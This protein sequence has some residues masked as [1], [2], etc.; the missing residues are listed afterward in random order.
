[1]RDEPRLRR[2]RH[3]RQLRPP[4][5]RPEGGLR[6]SHTRTLVAPRFSSGCSAGRPPTASPSTRRAPVAG[7][8]VRVHDGRIVRIAKDLT[9]AT[10]DAESTSLFVLSGQARLR[11]LS[12]CR[13]RARARDAQRGPAAGCAAPS[14]SHSR[15]L[16]ADPAAGRHPLRARA[17]MAT[18]VTSASGSWPPSETRWA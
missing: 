10:T 16:G 7:M 13:L 12:A 15:P 9:A 8:R 3:R 11:L 6:S 14:T 18:K 4:E 5:R 1:V 2:Y 17:A